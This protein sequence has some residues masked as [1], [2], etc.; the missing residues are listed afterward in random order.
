M[1]IRTE[2]PACH[3]AVMQSPSKYGNIVIFP[4]ND[5][6]KLLNLLPSNISGVENGASFSFKVGDKQYNTKFI[7]YIKVDSEKEEDS[8]K[9]IYVLDKDLFREAFGMKTKGGASGIKIDAIYLLMNDNDQLYVVGD[10]NFDTQFFLYR[11]DNINDG[12]MK[13]I[14]DDLRKASQKP[15]SVIE[16][17][18]LEASKKSRSVKRPSMSKKSATY[19]L[20]RSHTYGGD[21]EA[22]SKGIDGIE[23]YYNE[24]GK[25]NGVD[26]NTYEMRDYF[27]GIYVEDPDKLPNMIKLAPSPDEYVNSLHTIKDNNK[28]EIDSNSEVIEVSK[29][30]APIIEET[31]DGIKTFKLG[32]AVGGGDYEEASDSSSSDL[33]SASDSDSD[34]DGSESDEFDEEFDSEM[35]RGGS[36]QKKIY[37]YFNN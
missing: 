16:T 3:K 27:Y 4:C 30:S 35:K 8:L 1:S 9:S 15:S 29:P 6:A 12:R 18:K 21:K 34:S 31:D 25:A 23:K 17:A 11:L 20:N 24:I 22:I 2:F 14:V 37:S 10:A 7:G 19:R 28:Y 5:D 13:S 36:K 32:C 26:P 33:I